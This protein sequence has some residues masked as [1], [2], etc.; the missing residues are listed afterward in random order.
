MTYAVLYLGS[1]SPL[2]REA[3]HTAPQ[4]IPPDTVIAEVEDL[5]CHGK[6]PSKTVVHSVDEAR[7]VARKLAQELPKQ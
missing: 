6:M 4:P 3:V 7:A 5:L 1:G 2:H